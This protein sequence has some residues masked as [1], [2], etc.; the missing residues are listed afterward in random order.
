MS[1]FNND[2]NF[3]DFNPEEVTSEQTINCSFVIDVSSSV[4][5]YANELNDSFNTFIERMKK[6]HVANDLLISVTLFSN[7]VR[8]LTGFQP[9]NQLQSNFDFSKEI[10]GTTALYDGTNEALKNALDYRE[11][12]EQSGINVKTLVF[13]M[14]DGDDNES[15]HGAASK[16]K[17]Q[18]DS[19]L[20]E[21]RNYFSFETIL[22]GIGKENENSYM[23]AKEKMGIKQLATISNSADDIRKMIGFISASI[24]SV[25]TGAGM[26]VVNF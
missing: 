21:E 8:T 20:K 11:N 3:G 16:V 7:H 17:N 1:D 18:I 26:P 15:E 14:T 25:S 4:G 23:E 10:G 13:I 24:S 2:F 6:S 19:L 9:I 5:E 12:L 22:F